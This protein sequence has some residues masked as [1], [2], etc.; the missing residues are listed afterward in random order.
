M[1]QLASRERGSVAAWGGR[2]GALGRLFDGSWALLKQLRGGSEAAPGRLLRASFVVRWIFAR[3]VILRLYVCGSFW[4]FAI[5]IIVR[6]W[7][8]GSRLDFWCFGLCSRGRF[9]F[10][11]AES[12][13]FCSQDDLG[14]VLWGSFTLL[15]SSAL[16]VGL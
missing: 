6:S 16:K 3:G 2:K 5:V 10:L 8:S 12:C 11:F 4:Y 7:V 1:W 14:I 9:C 15:F 13:L